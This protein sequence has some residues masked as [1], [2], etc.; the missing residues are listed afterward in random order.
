MEFNWSDAGRIALIGFL[1]VFII[2]FILEMSLGIISTLVRKY[3]PKS[4][5]EKEKKKQ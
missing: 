3:G 1:G 4:T 5:E 2:L